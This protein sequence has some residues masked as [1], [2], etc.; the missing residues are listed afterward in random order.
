MA[1]KLKRSQYYSPSQNDDVVLSVKGVSK[2]FCRSLRRSLWYGIEDLAHELLGSNQERDTLR[3]EEFWALKNINIELRRGEALGLVGVNGAGKTT[4]LRIISG[5]IKPDEGEIEFTGRIAPLIALGAGF[6]PILTGRENIYANMAILGLTKQEISDRFED[7]VAFAEIGEALDAPVQTYSSG[8]AARLGFACAIF[9]EPEILLIDEVLAVGDIKFRNKCYRKLSTLREK[10]VSFIMVSHN[11][12]SILAACDNA[13]LLSQGQIVTQGNVTET[14]QKY[15]E[16][17]FLKTDKSIVN[18]LFLS[19][20]EEKNSTGVDITYVYFKDMKG[21]P[22]E[23][24]LSGTPTIFCVGVKSYQE[25]PLYLSMLVSDKYRNHE[26]ILNLN[27]LRDKQDFKIG[28]GKY[29]IQLK[30]PYLCLKSGYYQIKLSIIKNN[31]FIYD[32]IESF[33]FLVKDTN[34]NAAECEFFQPR[35]WQ[36]VEIN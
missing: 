26:I 19:P 15:E 21:N 36:I 12:N 7:V 23:Y 28:Q 33:D 6:S 25:T 9:V 2:K 31:I 8:M 35:T 14:M 10:G 17:L 1:E 22:L 16:I 13:V 5:L 4:L 32:T 20:K 34:Y 24:L 18:S 30:M 11:S 29:E 27:T 3:K